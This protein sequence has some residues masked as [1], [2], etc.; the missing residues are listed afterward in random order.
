MNI[1]GAAPADDMP[2]GRLVVCRQVALLA[3]NVAAVKLLLEEYALLI[4]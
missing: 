2:L 3:G 1:T 4:D